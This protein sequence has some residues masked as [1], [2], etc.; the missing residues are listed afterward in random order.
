MEKV[1]NMKK[2]I[3]M[4]DS[5]KNTMSSGTVCE[6]IKETLLEEDD[7]LNVKTYELADGGEGTEGKEKGTRI[8]H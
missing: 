6:I 3:V 4:P 2:I 5:F 8:Q 1:I 7:N